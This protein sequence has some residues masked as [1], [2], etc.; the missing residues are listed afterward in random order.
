MNEAPN[1]TLRKS[2]SAHDARNSRATATVYIKETLPDHSA[3]A[4]ARKET[5]GD[6][7]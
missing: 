4:H 7:P 5:I 2:G 1:N 6:V 3:S